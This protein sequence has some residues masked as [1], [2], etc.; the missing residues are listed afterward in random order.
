VIRLHFVVEGQTE[1]GF[2]NQTLAE[3]LGL[4]GVAVDARRVETSRERAR[5]Y[6]GGVLDYARARRDLERWMKQDR[7]ADAYFTTMFDLYALPEDFPGRPAQGADPYE[8]VTQLE[9]SFA[10]DLK[11]PRF[12]PHLQ[13]HEFEALLLADPGKLEDRFPEHA[14]GVRNLVELAAG[15]ASPELIDEGAETAPSKRIIREIPDYA[16]AKASAGPLVARAIGVATLRS[17]CPHFGAWVSR[18]EFLDA[19]PTP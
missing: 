19:R 2:V 7:H 13:L 10:D 5:I 11:H 9:Q 6:R 1:E 3:H 16:G 12:L 15:F 14:Q 4:H 8:R 17:R 18:L